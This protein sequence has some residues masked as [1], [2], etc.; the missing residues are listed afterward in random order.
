MSVPR[1]FKRLCGLVLVVVLT[2]SFALG[3]QPRQRPSRFDR[4]VIR[5]PSIAAGAATMPL[6]ALDPST[7]LRQAWESFGSAHGERWRIVLDRR[8]G[9]PLLVEGQGIPWI[10]GSGNHLS[11]P[12]SPTLESLERSLR[13]FVSANNAILMAGD[14]EMVLDRQASGK[15]TPE[16]W[17]VVF[18]REIGGVPVQGDKYLFTIGH[19]NLISFGATRWGAIAAGTLPSLS[20]GEAYGAL[21]AY[22]GIGTADDV[23]MPEPGRLVLL[24]LPA[25]QSA[26]AGDTGGP[27]GRETGGL[28]TGPVGAGIHSAL[29]WRMVLRVGGEPGRWVG[30]VEANSPTAGRILALFDDDHYAQAKGGVYPESDDQIC[31][32]GCEQ[33]GYPMPF[34]DISVNGSPQ[35]ANTM[36]LF[37]CTPGG[38]TATTSLAGPYARINDNCG[39][40]SESISCDNDLDLRTSAGADCDVPSGSSPGNTHSART[41]FYVVNRLAEHARAWLPSNTWLTQQ[42]TENVNINATCNAYWNGITL[43]MYKSGGG[44]NNTGEIAGVVQHEWGHG[45]DSNDGGGYDDPTEAYADITEFMAD[46]TSCIG[47][48]FW[49]SQQCGGYGNPCLNCTG[50]RDQD[51]DQRQNH[52]PSTPAGFVQNNCGGGDGPCGGEQHCEGYVSAEAMWDLAARDLP[53]LGL[54]A[55]TAWQV[56]DRLWYSSRS[57]SGGNAYNCSL[58]NSDGCGSNSW[59]SKLRTADD[60]DGNLNNGT[61]HG[62]AIFA[63]FDRHKIA[64]GAA[65]DPSNQNT[66]SCPALAAPALSAT[67]GSSSVSLSGRRSRTLPHTTCCATIPAAMARTPSLRPW[68]LPERPTRTRDW[69]T[70]SRSTTA[71]RPLGRTPPARGRFRTASRSPRSLSQARFHSIAEPTAARRRSRS[72]CVTPISVRR[73]RPQR[74]GRR[75]SLD[76]RRFC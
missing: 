73:R 27:A 38:A 13:R 52:A 53:A 7:P 1:S 45:L 55:A 36:G 29:A 26:G 22:M 33:A 51:W 35:T 25:E 56:T 48:G 14:A 44:C 71:C 74:S 10:A 9:A 69:R 61:P 68:R 16:T 67:A 12:T 60:D 40:A 57:G 31:P 62:S 20:A 66:S 28:Y 70:A 76:Q 63:A 4:L 5:D 19:G 65:S 8:T 34:A 21:T 18:N 58:P 49:Q 30:L 43:N 23:R 32:S 46:H 75:E 64:C 39:A 47:R 41:G 37:D 42:L 2:S 6:Q 17:I 54:D 24:P 11:D 72:R 50:I 3:F 15:L 59:F